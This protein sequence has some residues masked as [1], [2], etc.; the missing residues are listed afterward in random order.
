MK[1]NVFLVFKDILI[2]FVLLMI[3]FVVWG[4]VVNMIDFLVKVFSKIFIMLF[5]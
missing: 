4:V 2:F 3:C 5:L 1:N